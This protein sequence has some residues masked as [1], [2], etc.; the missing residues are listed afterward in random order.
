MD[1][2]RCVVTNCEHLH[3]ARSG[4]YRC[5]H[6]GLPPKKSYKSVDGRQVLGLKRCPKGESLE[7]CICGKR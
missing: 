7:W 1:T 5:I 6:P 2:V 3:C 4:Q